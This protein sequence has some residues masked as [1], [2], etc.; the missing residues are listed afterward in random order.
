MMPN[1]APLKSESGHR[2]G[3]LDTQISGTGATVSVRFTKKAGE[4]APGGG[5]FMRDATF[6]HQVNMVFAHVAGSLDLRG[7]T[8]ADLNLSGASIAG[9]FVLGG[10]HKSAVWTGNTGEPGTLTLHNTHIGNLMDAQD[11]WPGQGQLHL[12]G[13]TFNHLGGPPR[14]MRW[15]DSWARLDSDYSPAP[16]NQLATT[17]T[18]AGDRDAANDIR[19]YGRVRERETEKGLAFVWSGTHQALAGD[20]D[21]QGIYGVLQRSQ[22]RTLDRLAE[23]YL[24]RD[25]HRGLC[26]R[27]DPARRRLRPD[28]RL[29]TPPVGRFAIS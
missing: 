2:L 5:L 10:S 23:L 1:G 17:L 25:G 8:L 26:A 9:D 3:S 27:R 7:A 11:A 15:W 16:Y 29:L 18:S 28:P 19:Y 13:F 12:D 22:T 24:F 4:G 6:A 21:Q 20:R 14:G